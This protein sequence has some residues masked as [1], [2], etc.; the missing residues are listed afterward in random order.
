MENYRDLQERASQN[1]SPAQNRKCEKKFHKTIVE[2]MVTVILAK[3]STLGEDF[4]NCHLLKNCGGL[5]KSQKIYGDQSF[6]GDRA[7]GYSQW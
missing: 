3:A 1:T 6:I 7:F 5:P 4:L 2:P